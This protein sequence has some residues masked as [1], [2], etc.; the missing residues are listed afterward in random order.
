MGRTFEEE[1]LH[2]NEL[3]SRFVDEVERLCDLGECCKVSVRE[4]KMALWECVG[5]VARVLAYA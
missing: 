1:R 2:R 3:D 5:S 4:T